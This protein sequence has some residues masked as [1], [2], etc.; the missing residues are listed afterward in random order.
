MN[1][2]QKNILIDVIVGENI[3]ENKYLKILKGCP[4]FPGNMQ[5]SQINKICQCFQ[6]HEFQRGQD[7]CTEGEEGHSLFVICEG[8][9]DA[10]RNDVGVVSN[11]KMGDILGEVCLQSNKST[12]RT[13]TARVTSNTAQVYELGRD[14]YKAFLEP[15]NNAIAT[16]RG[17][18]CCIVMFLFSPCLHPFACSRITFIL[19][20]TPFLCCC[21]YIALLYLIVNKYSILMLISNKDGRLPV[22][23]K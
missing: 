18:C 2:D 17:Y 3:S 9:V 21:S 20:Y 19:T 23:T 13:A 10:I 4:L 8:K 1:E 5:E 22:K 11:F 12:K 6:L 16:V 15:Y 14:P 7:I